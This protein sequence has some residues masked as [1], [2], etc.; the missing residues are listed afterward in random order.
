MDVLP[1]GSFFTLRNHSFFED[2]EILFVMSHVI[3]KEDDDILISP[4]LIE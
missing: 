3:T 4:S 1:I 2:D